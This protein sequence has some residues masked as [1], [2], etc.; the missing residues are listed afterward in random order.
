MSFA[1][2]VHVNPV[3]DAPSISGPKGKNIVGK[4]D[5]KILLSS[6]GGIVL[7]DPDECDVDGDF[8]EVKVTVVEGKLRL[9]LSSATGLHLLNGEKP[10]GSLEFSARGGLTDLNRAL[11]DLIYQAQAEWSGVDQVDVW[12]SD[13]GDRKGSDSLEYY[14]NFTITV[15]AVDDTPKV[16]ST[17]NVHYL[18]EDTSLTINFITVSDPDP[19][20]IIS[21]ELNPEYGAINILPTLLEDSLWNQVKVFRLSIPGMKE[22]KQGALTLQGKVDDINSA[23]QMMAYIPLTNFGGQVVLSVRVTDRTGL[24]A[25]DDTYLYVRPINDPPVIELPGRD[26]GKFTLTTTA[27]DSGDA[28]L[29]VIITDVDVA[30]SS[31]LCSKTIGLNGRN[32]LS[33]RFTPVSGTIYIVAESA[34][35][36]WVVDASTVGP[37]ETLL[38]RGSVESLQTALDLGLVMYSAPADFTGHDTI[39]VE[40][41]DGENCGGGGLGSA[42]LT[43]GVDV[44][45][46]DPPLMI[47][48]DNNVPVDSVLFTLEDEPLKFP[49][50]LV[51]GGSVRE[52]APVEVAI[53]VVSGNVMLD[54]N[55]RGNIEILEGS[56]PVDGKVR[57]RGSPEELTAALTGMSF[58]PRPHFF[59]CWDRNGS[60][61]DDTPV[62]FPEVQGLLALARIN[63]ICTP[64]GE[65]EYLT[66]D[67][68]TSGR[69]SKKLNE[70][71]SMTS[72]RISVGWV[73]NPPTVD[74]PHKVVVASNFL[75]S[76]VPG[77]RVTDLDVMEAS[78]GRGRLEVNVSAS[79]GN[80]LAVDAFIALRNGLRNDGTNEHQVRLRGQPEYI[81]NVLETLTISHSNSTNSTT[82]HTGTRID[83][84][85][86]NVRDLGFSGSGGEKHATASI[87]IEA[88]LAKSEDKFEYDLFSPSVIHT[89]ED[90]SVALPD[91]EASF[92]DAGDN[93]ELTVILAAKE[94]YLSLGPHSK[95][96]A[97]AAAKEDWGPAITLVKTVGGAEHVLPEIQV[98]SLG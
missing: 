98:Y 47:M 76:P 82:I 53:F 40:V 6:G 93:E 84:I 65:G 61:M 97:V 90:T 44:A 12:V 20:S 24:T 39:R 94:G 51:T 66:S 38:L 33:L 18:D 36:V 32:A 58:E 49:D 59:G 31:D 52:R 46:Y 37:Q 28:I 2:E 81:N 70:S 1:L 77:V 22:E 60:C 67:R 64:D 14:H 78:E 87:V 54:P 48:F 26:G 11:Q 80:R 21:V 68:L 75:K 88:G 35:G 30:D 96:L 23:F 57:M 91:L 55:N 69:Q 43:I 17:G 19:G 56:K 10:S 8:M 63:I 62:R 25:D 9:P 72:L 45:P 85:L 89:M 95:G 7:D 27:G 5:S 74:A 86:I 29:G 41:D 50:V 4:E 71:W 15:E 3:N 16:R 79:M 34:V 13:L 83:E 42:T 73:N 92:I